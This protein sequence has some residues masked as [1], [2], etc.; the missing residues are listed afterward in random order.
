MT[1]HFIFGKGI[2]PVNRKQG[3]G[4]V[5]S[6]EASSPPLFYKVFSFLFFHGLKME[7][8]IVTISSRT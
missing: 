8:N 5:V 4:K 3:R 7:I 2:R 1:G 6:N